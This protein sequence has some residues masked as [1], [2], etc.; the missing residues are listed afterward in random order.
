MLLA[1]HFH[2]LERGKERDRLLISCCLSEPERGHR[3]HACHE[4]WLY[5]ASSLQPAGLKAG[6][7]SG[8]IEWIKP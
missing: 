8:Q 1:L 4:P 6:I 5:S 3:S 2:Q 7:F